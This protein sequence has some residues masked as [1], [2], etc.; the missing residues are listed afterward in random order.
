M[1]DELTAW[2]ARDLVRSMQSGDLSAATVVQAHLRRIAA[3]EPSVRA[4][5][6]FDA[7][8]AIEAAAHAD[9]R[10]AAGR[11]PAPLHGLPVGVKDIF[12]TADMPT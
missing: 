6:W 7:G 4:W 2:S 11:P 3:D 9:A 12:D 10:L 8:R 1:M 5:A